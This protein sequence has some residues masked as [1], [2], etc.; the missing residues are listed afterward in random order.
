MFTEQQ[1]RH[2][3]YQSFGIQNKLDPYVSRCVQRNIFLK[4]SEK[5]CRIRLA[6]LF[7]T[8]FVRFECGI[9]YTTRQFYKQVY[10]MSFY[11]SMNLLNIISQTIVSYYSSLAAYPF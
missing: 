4:K 10:I 2:H 3:K 7:Q 9:F 5:W 6:K 8:G 1:Q 11:G